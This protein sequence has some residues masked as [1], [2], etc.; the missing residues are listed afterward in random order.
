MLRRTLLASIAS[1]VPA[2]ALP[3]RT[4]VIIVRAAR[5]A[6]TGTLRFGDRVY[7]CALGRSGIVTNKR[8]GDGGTPAGIF[9]LREIRYRPDRLAPK[10]TDPSWIATTPAD[11]WCDD[12]ADLAY[13]KLVHLPFPASAERMW[14]DDGV[15]DALAVIG[16]NDAP[17]VPG[18]GSAIFLHIAHEGMSPTAGC[19]ALRKG[20]LLAVLSRAMPSAVIDIGTG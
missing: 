12:P 11:G 17:V 8:E 13:N 7:P 10:Q 2:S 9:A 5:G 4:G 3:K 19:I 1:L 18:K 16:Y 20:D 6:I 15:Y 14:R